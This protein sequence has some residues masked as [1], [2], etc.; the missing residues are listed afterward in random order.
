MLKKI[1]ILNFM[2][3]AKFNRQNK[4]FVISVM[5]LGGVVFDWEG[6]CLT[7]RGGV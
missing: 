7:G 4:I 3:D 5:G 1:Y 6:W 2:I